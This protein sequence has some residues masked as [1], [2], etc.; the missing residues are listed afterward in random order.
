MAS[1]V[2]APEEGPEG[3]KAEEG[4][5]TGVPSVSEATT[6]E[7]TQ[8]NETTNTD[9]YDPTV[10][11]FYKWIPMLYWLHMFFPWDILKGI[12]LWCTGSSGEETELKWYH[13]DGDRKGALKIKPVLFQVLASTIPPLLTS[14][15]FAL[16]LRRAFGMTGWW[17]PAGYVSVFAFLLLQRLVYFFANLLMGK[18]AEARFDNKYKLTAFLLR[19]FGI[20]ATNNLKVVEDSKKKSEMLT[21]HQNVRIF[22]ALLPAVAVA[23]TVYWFEKPRY[24][25]VCTVVENGTVDTSKLFCNHY[26]VCCKPDDIRGVDFDFISNFLAWVTSA[27]SFTQLLVRRLVYVALGAKNLSSVRFRRADFMT[28]SG[29]TGDIEQGPTHAL[30]TIPTEDLG[31]EERVPPIDMSKYYKIWNAMVHGKVE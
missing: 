9:Y 8:S 14:I 6:A 2:K 3:K 10:S 11:L 17:L 18:E 19:L 15:G 20:E 4:S 30:S 13:P 1:A 26:N 5:E 27:Y 23:I 12:L 24:G 25:M 22:A 16:A 28:A 31:H 29:E 21:V 7:P